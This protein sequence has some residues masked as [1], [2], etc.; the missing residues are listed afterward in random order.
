MSLGDL[1]PK[2]YYSVVVVSLLSH[3]K[4]EMIYYTLSKTW[5]SAFGPISGVG[6]TG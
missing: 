3:T 1:C 2:V 4:G 6:V 5:H